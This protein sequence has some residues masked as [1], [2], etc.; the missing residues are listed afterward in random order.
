MEKFNDILSQLWREACWEIEIDKSCVN[1][2]HL[3]AQ[4]IPLEEILVGRFDVEKNSLE[5]VAVGHA[6]ENPPSY[7]RAVLP[8]SQ[9]E[10]EQIVK[11]CR[12][13]K[14]LHLHEDHV[15]DAGLRA[16]LAAPARDALIGLLQKENDLLGLLLF[17]TAADESFSDKHAEM[18]GIILEPFSIA[19]ENHLRLRELDH[20]RE[21]AEA[22]KRFLLQRLHRDQIGD[23]IIGA[24]SG[25]RQV[26]SRVQLVAPSNVPVLLLG[27]TG[28]GK[29]LISREIHRL[30]P[31]AQ[32]PFLRVNCG[33]IP[34][35]LI[36]SQLFGHEKGA[37]TG[38]TASHKG[39]FE[40][41]DGGT[42]F[43]DE[44]G[45]LP[46]A[47][48]VR[49]LRILQD[50]WLERVGGRQPIHVDVRIVVATHQDLAAMVK[51]GAFREDLWYRIA[52]FPIL[53]PALA[54][55]PDDIP[56]LARHFAEKAA[57]RFMLPPQLPTADDLV[58]LRAYP[59]PGNIRELASVIDRAALL[60]NGKGL[61][62]NTALGWTVQ[63]KEQAVPAPLAA[64]DDGAPFHSLNQVMKEHIERALLIARG[65]IE[66]R[67][68]AAALL[69]IH[70]NT[71]RARM[72]KLG[73]DHRAFQMAK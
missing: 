54:E 35:E 37:F 15:D 58:L 19:L 61:A 63:G 45:E 28:T 73:I 16:L 42:L 30:S 70:P 14:I 55:R 2:A 60:G 72:R 4:H 46:L 67:A 66:G 48:Q 44:I 65:R 1:I 43:L 22:D 9:A 5:T 29:E 62:V 36:D 47:G 8:L 33:A 24:D 32:G 53:L 40:R 38:A 69:E 13:E 10:W 57:I 34:A 26:M 49:L 71:L 18:F 27:E 52:V 68:G 3:L 51:R 21:A 25:L 50:G 11:R 31:R 7:P 23:V 64:Q 17:S 6:R 20:L 59:W 39:W 12:A 41:A 56:A